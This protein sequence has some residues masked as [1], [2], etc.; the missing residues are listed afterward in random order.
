MVGHEMGSTCRYLDHGNDCRRGALSLSQRYLLT[1]SL[2]LQVA[3]LLM[4]PGAYLVPPPPR[5][6][7]MSAQEQERVWLSSLMTMI[8]F[9]EDLKQKAL[10]NTGN[11]SLAS[12]PRLT[13]SLNIY[14]L[15]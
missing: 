6:T 12:K 4:E 9:P 1:P 8:P 7:K 14:F 13:G 5:L 2:L 15:A 11:A 3:S 10:A